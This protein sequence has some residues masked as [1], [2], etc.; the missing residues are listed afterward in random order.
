MAVLEILIWI[1]GKEIGV[2][3]FGLLFQNLKISCQLDAGRQGERKEA[4]KNGGASTTANCWANFEF[5]MS[6][7]ADKTQKLDLKCHATGWYYEFA[8]FHKAEIISK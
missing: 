3:A 5:D 2:A 1:A 7:I 4:S 6:A 8:Y